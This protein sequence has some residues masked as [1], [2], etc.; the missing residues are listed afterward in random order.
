VPRTVPFR[1][2]CDCQNPRTS[3]ALNKRS[4][5]HL[6]AAYNLARWLTRD[7]HNA[8]M[9]QDAYVRALDLFD[10]F[11]GGNSRAWLLT[12]VRHTC[13]TCCSTIAAG[14]HTEFDEE[15]IAWMLRLE[16]RTL[17]LQRGQPNSLLRRRWKLCRMEY[18]EVVVLRELEGCRIR[19]IAGIT[20]LLSGRSVALG[21]CP[22][23]GCTAWLPDR[24][25]Q[26][27]NTTSRCIEIMTT[28]TPCGAGVAFAS[29]H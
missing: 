29:R 28:F 23:A 12:I 11:H 7:E 17:L 14:P 4:Y 27:A 6:A 18:R 15:S 25:H 2:P 13:Y 8:E 20:D 5:W 19:R 3:P 21:P 9:V 10:S 22:P 1:K 16:S 24:L 26:E